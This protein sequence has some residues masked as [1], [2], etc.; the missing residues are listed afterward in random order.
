[1]SQKSS[2]SDKIFADVPVITKRAVEYALT[3]LQIFCNCCHRMLET[4]YDVAV[5]IGQFTKAVAQLP[6]KYVQFLVS[7]HFAELHIQ[8]RE[9]LE[10]SGGRLVYGWR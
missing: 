9:A 10:E 4:P 3:E 1:M 6:Y 2:K 8:V 5:M 7:T